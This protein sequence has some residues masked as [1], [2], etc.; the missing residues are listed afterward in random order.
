MP[1]VFP[2]NVLH[3]FRNF[4][5]TVPTPHTHRSHVLSPLHPPIYF[6]SPVQQSFL[7]PSSSRSFSTF[8]YSILKIANLTNCFTT[9]SGSNSK[10][11]KKKK[12]KKKN[13]SHA[14]HSRFSSSCNSQKFALYSPVQCTRSQ[15]AVRFTLSCR[16]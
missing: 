13:N 8:A 3:P 15:Q 10:P 14:S 12:I 16:A 9:T 11:K 6:F 7:P 5:T 2:R 4:R 1:T